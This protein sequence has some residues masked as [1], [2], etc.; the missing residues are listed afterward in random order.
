MFKMLETVWTVCIGKA[1]AADTHPESSMLGRVMCDSD[2]PLF[3][4]WAV[5]KA[6]MVLANYTPLH[7][8]LGLIF[9]VIAIIPIS[10]NLQRLWTTMKMKLKL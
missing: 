1:Q 10:D 6:Q 4:D 2:V 7:S 9:K 8:D 3:S 5:Q